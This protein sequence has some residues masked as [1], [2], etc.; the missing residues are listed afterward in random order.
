MK[1]WI[2]EIRKIYQKSRK[3]RQ[4]IYR[5]LDKKHTVMSLA[6]FLYEQHRCL[7]P[8]QHLRRSSVIR[9]STTL[10]STKSLTIWTK[11]RRDFINWTW[12]WREIQ[13]LI[14]FYNGYFEFATMDLFDTSVVSSPCHRIAGDL[15]RKSE[16]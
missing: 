15:T 9:S 12:N 11:Q 7:Q 10:S 5:E 14:W 3:Y 2:V 13:R 1:K 6:G 16:L 4:W 8:L